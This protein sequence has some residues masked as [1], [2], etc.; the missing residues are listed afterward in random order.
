[1]AG[2]KA[3]LFDMIKTYRIQK[4]AS[5]SFADLIKMGDLFDTRIQP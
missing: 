2:F 1:M 4:K 3:E 5:R